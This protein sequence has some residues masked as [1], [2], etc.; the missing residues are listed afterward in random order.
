MGWAGPVRVLPE[1][2][3]LIISGV[4]PLLSEAKLDSSC[5]QLFLP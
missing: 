1:T 3:L 2:F 4:R 5:W